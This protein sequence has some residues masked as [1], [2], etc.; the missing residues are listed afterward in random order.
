M[1]HGSSDSEPEVTGMAGRNMSAPARG[2]PVFA[3]AA[4]VHLDCMFSILLPSSHID[5]NG[6]S[7]V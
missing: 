3:S 5:R 6:M 1:A 2:I 4:A 7:E